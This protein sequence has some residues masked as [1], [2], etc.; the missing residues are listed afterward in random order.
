MRDRIKNL[1]AAIQEDVHDKNVMVGAFNLYMAN[2]QRRVEDLFVKKAD[3]MEDP[4]VE[5]HVIAS[6]PQNPPL[7]IKG[8]NGERTANKVSV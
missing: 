1:E 5:G 6:M 2:T 4:R 3:F 8:E 7:A